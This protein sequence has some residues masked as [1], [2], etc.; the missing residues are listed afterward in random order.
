MEDEKIIELFFE[1]SEEAIME[2]SAK[3][4]KLLFSV[5]NNILNNKEDAM[6]CVNDT[7]LGAWKT[8]PPQKPN[9]LTAFICKI[10]RNLSLK[11]YRDKK[12][13]KRNSTFDVSME[14]LEYCI[15]S[16]SVEEIWSAKE[17]GIAIDRFL[18]TLDKDNRVMFLRRYWFFDSISDISD[19]FSLTENNVSVK[20]LRIRKGLRSFL[21]KE[22]FHI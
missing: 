3:Y 6:E 9:P 15:P 20:L 11:K 7:Y 18:N 21:E 5:S 12:A 16:A 22:G 13:S 14:E 17:L 1:R 19:L 8:I 4:E 10:V 2:L